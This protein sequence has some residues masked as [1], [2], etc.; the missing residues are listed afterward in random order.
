MTSAKLQLHHQRDTSYIRLN[1]IRMF[2]CLSFNY[3]NAAIVLND[4]EVWHGL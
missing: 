4:F 2:E 3:G 1:A